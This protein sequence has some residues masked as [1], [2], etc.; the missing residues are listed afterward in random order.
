MSPFPEETIPVSTAKRIRLCLFSL[1]DSATGNIKHSVC[2]W[3]TLKESSKGLDHG[4]ILWARSTKL[5]VSIISNSRCR[6]TNQILQTVTDSARP[7]L[8]FL[9]RS[10]NPITCASTVHPASPAQDQVLLIHTAQEIP[11]Y[12][13]AYRGT[14]QRCEMPYSNHTHKTPP[15]AIPKTSTTTDL[16]G[17]AVGQEE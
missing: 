7:E 15:T 1:P 9:N 2:A 4:S 12:S 10:Q 14:V 11:Y 8:G 17:R 3:G 16:C 5:K 6:Q 13:M